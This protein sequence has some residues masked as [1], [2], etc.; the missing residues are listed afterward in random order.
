MNFA[1][2]PKESGKPKRKE[3]TECVREGG[4]SRQALEGDGKIYLAERENFPV[5]QEY[6]NSSGKK[7]R[8]SGN[9]DVDTLCIP[10]DWPETDLS[11]WEATFPTVKI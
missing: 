3:Q 2:E 7:K 4:Q 10:P 8:S 11:L 5:P 9:T 6:D 1:E